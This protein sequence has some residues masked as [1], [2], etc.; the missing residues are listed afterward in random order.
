MLTSKLEVK[1][2]KHASVKQSGLYFWAETTDP[3]GLFGGPP[4][5]MVVSQAEGFPA[6]EA[7]DDWFAKWDDADKMAQRLARGEA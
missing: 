5:F 7:W 2:R 6:T 4:S 3:Q 1:E